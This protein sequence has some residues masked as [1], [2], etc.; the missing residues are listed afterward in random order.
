MFCYQCEQT[1]KGTGCTIQ[2]VCGK[3][4][5]TATL[6]D[7]L[8]YA[9]EGIS[10]LAKKM[11]EHGIPY[12]E[13]DIFCIQSLFTM[14]TNVNFDPAKLQN[15]IFKANQIKQEM[16]GLAEKTNQPWLS[17]LSSLPKPFTFK[18]AT[19]LE[20]LL[21]QGK[22]HS[23]LHHIKEM[24]EE[25][26][27]VFHLILY[28]L[29]GTAAYA[30][31]AYIL[32]TQNDSVF[33]FFHETL[34]FL[35]STNHTLDELIA[36]ALH[37]GEV[38]LQVMEML[39]RANTE[40]YG[41]PE[42]TEVRTTEIKGK[43]ILVSGHDFLD[44]ESILKQTE[45]KNINVYTHGEMLPANAYPR[46]KKY[47]H[48]IGNFGTAW[49]NQQKEFPLFPGPIVMTTNCIQRPSALYFDR[50]F[51]S[52]V[53]AFPQVP[54]ILDHDFSQVIK[55]AI[56]MDGFLETSPEKKITIGFARHTILEKAETI[57]KLITEK[58]INH[59]FL[60][61]GCDGAKPGRSYYTDFAK[62]TPP[63]TLIL[64]LACGKYR[65][66]HLD[67]G[68]IE[69]IPRL[70]DVGQCNDAYSAVQIALALS[71]A[72]HCQV[73]D[74][75]L[76]FVLSW[77]EQKAVCVLLTLLY[78]GIK[79]IHLGPSIPAF[80]KPSIWKVLQD[81]LNITQINTPEEDLKEMLS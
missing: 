75:P 66:N 51:T 62:L 32:G 4:D 13:A 14:I 80:I 5:T 9:I 52:G 35:A 61:G 31:H 63:D 18:P 24:G 59:I 46:L 43:A 39:D 23:L 49:Q 77:Y 40:T 72:L 79:N 8:L 7:L 50:M 41:H 29:K 3:D 30:D 20:G 2:G 33:S 25:A 27:G 58:K 48:L 70:L 10:V 54:H 36:T 67:L 17:E 1:A 19:T 65:L 68:T 47:N 28:G 12:H 78:L 53:V 34:S 37:V 55:K 21:E 42:P 22:E 76:S 38:N 56:E 69:G 71:H 60:I 64:T 45:G 11:R 6:Q 15:M 73:N 81:K 26:A 16:V 44:L 57:L 74:L